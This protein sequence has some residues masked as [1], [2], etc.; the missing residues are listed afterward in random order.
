MP[1]FTIRDLTE[2]DIQLIGNYWENSNFT[3]LKNMG[4][5]I[6]KMFTRDEFEQVMHHQLG[7]Q[8][9]E[10]KSFCTIWLVDGSPIGHCN[11]NPTIYGLEAMFH[12]HIWDI[13]DRNSGHGL[14]L[15]PLSISRFFEI[16]KLKILIAEPFR[17]NPAPN[18]LLKNLGFNLVKT[19]RTVPGSINLEQ[20]VNRWELTSE[21]WGKQSRI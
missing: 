1:E 11:T 2:P 10:K 19:Y 21:D 6:E 8:I 7:L 17:H 13:K 16:L 9:R 20:E 5:D 4:V 15:L 18:K 3:H 12:L 14:H